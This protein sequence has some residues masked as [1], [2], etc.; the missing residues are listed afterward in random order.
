[1]S[2]PPKLFRGPPLGNA[3]VD[4]LREFLQVSQKLTL[5]LTDRFKFR[6]SDLAVGEIQSGPSQ[7]L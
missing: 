4:G 3:R 5:K 7:K 1:M 2:P 6:A